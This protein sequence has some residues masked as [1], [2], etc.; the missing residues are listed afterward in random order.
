MAGAWGRENVG[1]GDEILV[2]EMEHHS[3]IVPWQLLRDEKDLVLKIAP[4]S[5]DGEFLLDAFKE[6]LTDRT[7]YNFV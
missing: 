1:E 4:I 6:M 3:N 5:D 2:T 7:S